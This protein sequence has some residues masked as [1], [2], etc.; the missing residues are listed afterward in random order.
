[1]VQ[2]SNRRG[3]VDHGTLAGSPGHLPPLVQVLLPPPSVSLPSPVASKFPLEIQSL[4]H[5]VG[6][7]DSD[8]PVVSP[9][10]DVVLR[11]AWGTHLLLL[12]LPQGQV[13]EGRLVHVLLHQVLIPVVHG[14]ALAAAASSR[15]S[16]IGVVLV[17]VEAARGLS[18]EGVSLPWGVTGEEPMERANSREGEKGGIGRICPCAAP[19]GQS[20]RAAPTLSPGA[21]RRTST[22]RPTREAL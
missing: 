12:L 4:T 6:K 3:E 11:E 7:S 2:L 9:P 19:S 18:R 21:T 8:H 20:T 1:M 16:S 15:G 14:A 5:L 10:G 17:L 22:T 13:T